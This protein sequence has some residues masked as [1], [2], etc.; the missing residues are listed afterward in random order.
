V[1][2]SP[3]PAVDPDAA[4][5]LHPNVETLWKQRGAAIDDGA[6]RPYG[7]IRHA[8]LSGS[9]FTDADVALLRPFSALE[10]VQLTG[11]QVTDAGLA[12]LADLT[13]I[14]QL[15]LTETA[16]TDAGLK[17]LARMKN[18]ER[19]HLDGTAVTD[20]G[21]DSLH[22]LTALQLV[23][24]QRTKV[25]DAG[26][27][28]ARAKLPNTK[29]AQDTKYFEY[30]SPDGRFSAKFPW[31]APKPR[32]RTQNTPFGAVTDTLYEVNNNSVSAGVTVA[33]FSAPQL[34]GADLEQVATAGR[35]AIAREY[36]G[37][38]AKDDRKT[39]GG[40]V[41]R[42]IG[43]EFPA[44]DA[45]APAHFRYLIHGRRLYTVA[46]VAE[47]GISEREKDAFFGSFKIL[48]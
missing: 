29:F 28:R 5:A 12:S 32:T 46:M 6:G 14:R 33:D 42:D 16:V 48:K 26:V 18:L 17:H 21:L 2:G 11:S 31:A 40:N 35:D 13:S 23:A 3:A 37:T 36:G 41:V 10:V 38:V 22:G 27:E 9:K 7:T 45:R 34:A 8:S 1:E 43:I 20:A 19:L 25:T 39:F 30:T 24:V 15:W 47:F 44:R 4:P